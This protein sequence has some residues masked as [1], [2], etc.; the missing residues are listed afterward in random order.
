[1]LIKRDKKAKRSQSGLVSLIVV[2]ILAVVMGL[3]AIGFSK[4]MDRELR[5][6]LDQELSTQAYYSALAGLDDARAYLAAGGTGFNTCNGWQNTALGPQYFMTDL[7][8]GNLA[9]Y[10]CVTIDTNPDNLSY[11]INRDQSVTFAVSKP[12]LGDMYFG[13]QR[14]SNPGFFQALEAL[15][16]LPQESSAPANAAGLLEV[17]LYPVPQGFAGSADTNATLNSL[18]RTYY[19]YP[20]NGTGTPGS[21]PYS[22]NGNFVP[23]NCKN[24]NNNPLT[25]SAGGMM[26]NTKITG[27]NGGVNT[28]YVKLTAR[29]API[30]VNIQATNSGGNSSQTLGGVQAIVDVTGQGTDVLQRIRAR[31]ALG[32]QYQTPNF[33]LQSMV[34]ICKG[35]DAPLPLPNTY[36]PPSLDSG[37][38]TFNTDSACRWPSTGGAVGSSASDLRPH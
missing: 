4:L 20:N 10:T 5:Q 3:V 21:T 28:Y 31:V 32:N 12:N 34:A 33:G 13:W 16:R 36:G 2:S 19:M 24:P 14:N 27:L 38:S 6:S 1:M 9:K 7:S 22:S 8:G 35:F 23:G 26:C 15:G 30:V 17:S 18:A 11:P 37:I 25:G 29:Y